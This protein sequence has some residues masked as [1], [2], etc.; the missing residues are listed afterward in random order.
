MLFFVTESSILFVLCP[1]G[2]WIPH[3]SQLPVPTEFVEKATL[4][5]WATSLGER[6]LRQKD[7]DTTPNS[8]SRSRKNARQIVTF[9]LFKIFEISAKRKGEREKKTQRFRGRFFSFHVV[10]LLSPF[11]LHGKRKKKDIRNA[12][13]WD[14]VIFF[15]PLSRTLQSWL[16]HF[17]PAHT[18]P[19]RTKMRF[20]VIL[21]WNHLSETT[22][23]LNR[24]NNVL[25]SPSIVKPTLEVWT[26]FVSWALSLF[27]PR[28]ELSSFLTLASANLHAK[29]LLGL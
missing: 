9:L 27:Y 1:N 22:L 19:T 20:F 11:F 28:K 17:S 29:Y 15:L 16:W 21:L 6:S 2:D 5:K 26:P 4:S 3:R 25:P 7:D 24:P 23:I 12:S 18:R 14:R 13:I 10:S 8:H